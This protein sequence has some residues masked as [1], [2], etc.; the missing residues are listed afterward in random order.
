VAGADSV[1]DAEGAGVADTPVLEA[2]SAAASARGSDDEASAAED[3]ADAV[4]A[5]QVKRVVS[6]RLPRAGHLALD[7]ATGS[8]AAAAASPGPPTPAPASATTRSGG[9]SSSS[10]VDEVSAVTAGPLEIQ[11]AEAAVEAR[12]MVAGT[13]RSRGMQSRP[14]PA[15]LQVTPSKLLGS[16]QPL[17]KQQAPTSE[18]QPQQLGRGSMDEGG[19]TSA[20]SSDDDG[21]GSRVSGSA[22]GGAAE[23][24]RHLRD[25]LVD[26]LRHATLKRLASQM[27][28]GAWEK[29]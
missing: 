22:G 28:Q 1:A 5:R 7:S 13:S 16:I 9:G 10:S 29:G 21:E 23:E 20:S 12:P 15:R 4:D 17:K 18:Q 11:A 26:S 3:A 25:R 6:W 24:A 27:N 8:P 19:P 2:V 14:R